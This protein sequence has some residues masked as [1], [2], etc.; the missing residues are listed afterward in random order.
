MIVKADCETDLALHSTTGDGD[1]DG[2]VKSLCV[3]TSVLALDTTPILNTVEVCFSFQVA[4][5]NVFVWQTNQTNSECPICLAENLGRKK[6]IYMVESITQNTTRVQTMA[7]S[8]TRGWCDQT[9]G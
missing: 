1:R 9:P 4:A 2:G 5:Q 8:S 6:S 7:Q 3:D